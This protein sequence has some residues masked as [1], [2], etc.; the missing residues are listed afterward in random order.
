M[1]YYPYAPSVSDLYWLVG[2]GGAPTAFFNGDV[3]DVNWVGA[4]TA[5]DGLYSPEVRESSEELVQAD[6]GIHG[7]FWLGRRP[8]VLTATVYGHS[9]IAQRTAKLDLINRASAA[10]RADAELHWYPNGDTS[11]EMMTW[12]RR[13]TDPKLSGGWVKEVQIPLVSQYARLF[14][15]TLHTV[16]TA[17]GTTP[18]TLLNMENRGSYPSPP[19]IRVTGP[20]TNPVV[21][22]TS[23]G[24]KV[25]FKA[26]AAVVAGAWVEVDV[27]NHTAVD[28]LGNDWTGNIDFGA[29]TWPVL[30]GNGATDTFELTG[31]GSSA[32]TKLRLS[33]RYAW[34]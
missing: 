25:Q 21:T 8:I 32:A 11:M 34:T 28:N 4:L 33:Y 24:L 2:P 6:G 31:T 27:L 7:Q 16:E 30:R 19:I 1:A 3:N 23:T 13:Q 22:N 20:V 18:R 9:T 15:A 17:A 26:G 29:S 10:L 5:V 14:S 12:V